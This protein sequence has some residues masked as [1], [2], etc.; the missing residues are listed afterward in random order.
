MCC[1][2]YWYCS[3][4]RII[5]YVL[6]HLLVLH[7]AYSSGL[8]TI[9][10]PWLLLGSIAVAARFQ[11]ARDGYAK[12]CDSVA[13]PLIRMLDAEQAHSVAVWAASLGLA[14]KVTTRA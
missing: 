2:I 1:V 11:Q 14:P 4:Q 12:L 3:Q 13:M 5:S 6:S 10:S 9:L 7:V 8:L